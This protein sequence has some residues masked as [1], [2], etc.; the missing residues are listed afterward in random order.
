MKI[1]YF[2]KLE[3]FGSI[4]IMFLNNLKIEKVQ[5]LQVTV[6]CNT[7]MMPDTIFVYL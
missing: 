2:I 5:C 4:N 6:F 7:V 1:M 3:N